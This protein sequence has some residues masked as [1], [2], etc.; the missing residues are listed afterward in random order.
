LWTFVAARR[1]GTH[2][3]RGQRADEIV[4]NFKRRLLTPFRAGMISVDN[5]PCGRILTLADARCVRRG[6]KQK[7]CQCC[8]DFVVHGG[9][10]QSSIRRRSAPSYISI[11]P[12]NEQLL[13][14]RLGEV[15]HSNSVGFLNSTFSAGMRLS[16]D[17][18]ISS[19]VP[20]TRELVLA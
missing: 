14:A 18:P 9:T 7:Q 15:R 6:R 3:A 16:A 17:I 5:F 2:H 20:I 1:Q 12:R 4:V 10:P 13:F 11:V 19:R 8:K